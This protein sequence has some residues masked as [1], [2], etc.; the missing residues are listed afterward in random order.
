M[1]FLIQTINNNIEHDFA[2]T[3]I[4]SIKYQNWIQN[5][6]AIT[7]EF[8]ELNST[9]LENNPDFIPIG[10]VEFVHKYLNIHN[11]KTPQPINIPND[12]NLIKFTGRKIINGTEKDI[13]NEKFVKSNDKLK[14][15]TNICDENNLPPKGNYQISEILNDI[16]SEWRAFIYK[17]QLVGLQNYL[18]EFYIFPNVNKI[19]EMINSYSSQ[20][21]AYTLDVALTNNDTLLI[22]VHHFY[23]CGLY[24][25]ADH[26]ILPFMF[27]KT[28]YSLIGYNVN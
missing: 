17:K 2:F 23:S 3:L 12:L 9:Y 13:Q 16:R 18:G 19:N 11:N 4:K 21:I 22:E 28:F 6:N 24:G 8:S 10:S 25:F 14:G 27:A 1:K 26:R 5:E 7:Y 20:P 15:Y